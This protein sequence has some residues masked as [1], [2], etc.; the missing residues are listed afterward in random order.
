MNFTAE[1]MSELNLLAQFQKGDPTTGIKVHASS[2]SPEV[3]AAAQRLH[4]KGLTTLVDGGYLTPRGIEA[5]T[6]AQ[7]LLRVLSFDSH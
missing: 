4:E 6:H 3:V 5:S 2:A 1:H 7:S